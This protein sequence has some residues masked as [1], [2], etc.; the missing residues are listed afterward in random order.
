MFLCHFAPFR[1][2]D[3]EAR[4]L[5]CKAILTLAM[6]LVAGDVLRAQSASDELLYRQL[7]VGDK[8]VAVGALDTIV[9]NPEAIS[10]AV[11]YSAVGAAVREKRLEDA[12]FLFYIARFRAQFD[13]GLFPPAGPLENSPLPAL[14]ALQQQWGGVI[15]P[16]LMA[17]PRAFANVIA[18]VKEWNPKVTATYH[19]G[20]EYV[21]KESEEQAAAAMESGRK[22][23]LET[24]GGLCTLLQDGTYYAAF[25]ICQEYNMKRGTDRPAKED[26]DTALLALERIEKEKGIPGIAAQAKK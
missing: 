24:M 22:Q 26:Y 14:G 25:R 18:R 5:V 15:N 23:F 3:S 9:K 2:K 8:A 16:A 21:R 17:N 13:K 10:A 6:G 11:L 4:R 19:P 12:G 20:W 1:G 7:A